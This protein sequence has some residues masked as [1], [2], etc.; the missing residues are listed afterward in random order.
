MMPPLYCIGW[1]SDSLCPLVL[2]RRNTSR[3]YGGCRTI[4]LPSGVVPCD[5]NVYLASL[6]HYGGIVTMVPCGELS[7]CV[8]SAYYIHTD[9]PYVPVNGKWGNVSACCNPPRSALSS[10][11]L[12]MELPGEVDIPRLGAMLAEAMPWT[13]HHPHLVIQ[14]VMPAR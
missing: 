2:L 10:G 14:A 5:D 12:F 6:G 9:P 13:T 3:W 4:F 8:C 11:R 1:Y 7:G